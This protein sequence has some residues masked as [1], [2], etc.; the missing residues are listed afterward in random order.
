MMIA[1]AKLIGFLSVVYF[2][3]GLKVSDVTVTLSNT[4]LCL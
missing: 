3:I 2:S 1:Y 4:V